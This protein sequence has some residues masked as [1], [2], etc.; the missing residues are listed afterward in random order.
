[1]VWGKWRDGIQPSIM[2][3]PINIPEIQEGKKK[4]SSF[5]SVLWILSTFFLSQILPKS[6]YLKE[7]FTACLLMSLSQGGDVTVNY[8]GF[9]PWVRKS[10]PIPTDMMLSTEWAEDRGKTDVLHL[11]EIQERKGRP[12]WSVGREKQ[13]SSCTVCAQREWEDLGH[14]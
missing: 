2:S 1:M 3:S 5:G 6:G 9:V 10:L 7:R 14:S 12:W 11:C 4:L 13:I 8:K